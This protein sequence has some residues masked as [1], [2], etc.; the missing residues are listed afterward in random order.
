MKK[1]SLLAALQ[2]ILFFF[3]NH[4]Y[5]FD[6]KITHPKITRIAAE[7]SKILKTYLNDELGFKNGLS[8]IIYSGDTI[9]KILMDGSQTED[10]GTLPPDPFCSRGLNHFYNPLAM[11]TDTDTHAGGLSDKIL[12]VSPD[13]PYISNLKWATSSYCTPGWPISFNPTE[14]DQKRTDS[15][16]YSWFIARSAFCEA[17]K[18]IYDKTQRNT[19]FAR[20]F[21]SLGQVVHLLQDMA[22]P[23]HVRNDM[24]G[25]LSLKK[26]K[27]PAM[28][29]GNNFETYV[30]KH[31]ELVT[32]SISPPPF[33]KLTD[34]WDTDKYNGNIADSIGNGLAEYTN[35]NFLSDYRLLGATGLPHPAAGDGSWEVTNYTA[36]DL[37]EGYRIYFEKKQGDNVVHLMAKGYWNI[38]IS[39]EVTNLLDEICYAE[40]AHKLIPKAIG[41]S[42][43]L[44]NYFFRGTL[45]VTEAAIIDGDDSGIKKIKAKVLNTTPNEAMPKGKLFAFARYKIDP[46]DNESSYAVSA[47][48]PDKAIGSETPEEFTF[49]FSG[50][51]A[52]PS[53]VT[54]LYL[55]VVYYGTLGQEV[56]TGVAIGMAK[57][58]EYVLLRSG[59]YCTLFSTLSNSIPEDIKNPRFEQ[60]NS[61]GNPLYPDAKPYFKFPELCTSNSDFGAYTTEY[62]SEAA[63]IAL[64]EPVTS[65]AQEGFDNNQEKLF[66]PAAKYKEEGV[67]ASLSSFDYYCEGPGVAFASAD[68]E[69]SGWS[70]VHS[71]EWDI[72]IYVEGAWNKIRL[73]GNGGPPVYASS[74]EVITHDTD[75]NQTYVGSWDYEPAEV[76]CDTFL[77]E[78][79]AYC[80]CVSN[81]AGQP[82]RTTTGRHN[83]VFRTHNWTNYKKYTPLGPLWEKYVKEADSK[84]KEWGT[85]LGECSYSVGMCGYI[86]SCQG[87]CCAIVYPLTI[88]YNNSWG[89]GRTTTYDEADP[90]SPRREIIEHNYDPDYN[91]IDGKIQPETQLVMQVHYHALEIRFAGSTTQV[92]PEIHVA[93]QLDRHFGVYD[94]Q[95]GKINFDTKADGRRNGNFEKA[96]QQLIEFVMQETA[97]GKRPQG[98]A[99]SFM[100][101]K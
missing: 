55:H 20:A 1:Y 85:F 96:A 98:L 27:P 100:I 59:N 33:S 40:Y 84:T 81:N 67:P 21:R 60:K 94:A 15:N 51:K 52:I 72:N 65:T 17:L 101:L 47:E 53:N 36:V 83:D 76:D 39:S 2:I 79:H 92:A 16:Y 8:E 38:Y 54:E 78:C 23:A 19:Y 91:T 5:P 28:P 4:A 48:Q 86:V 68:G 42:T 7:N 66:D 22:V 50:S 24:R 62:L 45:K 14:N 97:I 31:S 90:G 57:V 77:N 3:S 41:Y 73:Q 75:D 89:A 64:F 29:V 26:A 70:K 93:A 61:S 56:D 82:T 46:K 6:D 88:A 32:G 13:V 95:T 11:T 18:T 10:S 30:E 9:E 71:E 63:G 43:G 58:G 99:A 25:H 37:R 49:D 44:I 34:F 69:A 80:T 12:I 35:A 87:R 74:Y